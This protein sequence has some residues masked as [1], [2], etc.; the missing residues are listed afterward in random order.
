MRDS[1]I[2]KK[3]NWIAL[4]IKF[5]SGTSREIRDAS[6]NAVK[7]ILIDA[8]E[9]PQPILAEVDN[10]PVMECKCGVFNGQYALRVEQLLPSAIH[11][12]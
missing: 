8:L 1:S 4:N 9:I 3:A 7:Q 11:E 6:I 5:K 2:V 12:N 10:V